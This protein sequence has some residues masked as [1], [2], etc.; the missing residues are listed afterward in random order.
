[1]NAYQEVPN[2]DG[3]DFAVYEDDTPPA[4]GFKI[5]PPPATL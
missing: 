1:M 4:P 2:T 3:D 5:P